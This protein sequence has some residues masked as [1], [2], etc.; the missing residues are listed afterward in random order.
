M[1]LAVAALSF[2]LST[3]LGYPSP[4]SMAPAITPVPPLPSPTPPTPASPPVTD[5]ARAL[6]V[7]RQAEVYGTGS[8]LNVRDGQGADAPINFCLRDG[9]VVTLAE[10][11]VERDGNRWWR[12]REYPGWAADAFLKPH[13]E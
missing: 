7:G 10:G 11:P 2:L 1:L 12:V 13:L 6:A 5:T 3:V 9:T 8:C 4:I